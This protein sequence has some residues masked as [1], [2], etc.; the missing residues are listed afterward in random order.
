MRTLQHARRAEYGAGE[1][2]HRE[3]AARRAQPG[4]TQRH[5]PHDPQE[6]GRCMPRREALPGLDALRRRLEQAEI[7]RIAAEVDDVP[8]AVARGQQLGGRGRER[9]RHHAER[10]EQRIARRQPAQ[11]ALPALPAQP[12]AG[13]HQHV[14]DLLGGLVHHRLEEPVVPQGEDSEFR[15][16]E[17]VRQP[18]VEVGALEDPVKQQRAQREQRG[19][20]QQPAV[21]GIERGRG[22]CGQWAGEFGRGHGLS[23]GRWR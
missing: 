23:S 15:I 4:R 11:P 6:A 21:R 16:E 19:L 12:Q 14:G 20:C 18:A 22:G 9:D 13:R 8:R 3:G 17:G 2:A 1:Q 7:G 5:R 10:G